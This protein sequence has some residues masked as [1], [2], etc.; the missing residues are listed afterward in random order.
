MKA[1][2]SPSVSDLPEGGMTTALEST[3]R[4]PRKISVNVPT[5]TIWARVHSIGYY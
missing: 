1:K 3:E 5:V 2:N 4:L